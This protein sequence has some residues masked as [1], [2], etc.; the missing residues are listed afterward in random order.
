MYALAVLHNCSKAAANVSALR[1]AGAKDVLVKYCDPVEHD[2]SI[3][4]VALLTLVN[5]MVGFEVESLEVH[6]N[7]LA[8]I[9]KFTRASVTNT[10]DHN[11]PVTF[12][13]AELS[14][15]F[16]STEQVA[17][18]CKLSKNAACRVSLVK[19]NVTEHLVRLM[20]IGDQTEQEVACNAVWE[21]L[22]EQTVEEVIM[23]PRLTDVVKKLKDTGVKEVADAANRLLV[24]IRQVLRRSRG[25]CSMNYCCKYA[26]CNTNTRTHA[27]THATRT[28]LKLNYAEFISLRTPDWSC[29][30][31]E[32]I[33]CS[34]TVRLFHE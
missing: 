13:S 17:A 5:I 23:S 8:T 21:L 27:R 24:K 6:D 19:K 1:K 34:V 18:I 31:S 32:H 29:V 33:L 7:M 10:D 16:Y 14:F 4:F 25:M 30:T 2:S 11:A 9:V 20:E 3:A 26:I 28:L 22:S 12:Q 15:S